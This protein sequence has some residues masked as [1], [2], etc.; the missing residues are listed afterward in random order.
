MP[1]IQEPNPQSYTPGDG[2]QSSGDGFTVAFFIII[3]VVVVVALF[4]RG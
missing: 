4:N 1:G 3:A 2:N